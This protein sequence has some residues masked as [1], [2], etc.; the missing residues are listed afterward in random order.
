MIKR[1]PVVSFVVLTYLITWPFHTLGFILGT[2]RLSSKP[3]LGPLPVCHWS[4]DL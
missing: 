4:H 3:A 1:Y 2:C